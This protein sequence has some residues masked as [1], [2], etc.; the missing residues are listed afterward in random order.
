MNQ[1][2][3]TLVPKPMNFNFK[4]GIAGTLVA[5]SFLPVFAFAEGTTSST[6]SAN[7]FCA[8]ISTVSTKVADQI[9]EA[10]AK[11][12]KKQEDRST[13]IAKK[14]GDAD[15]RRA[16][17]RTT[18]DGKRASNW[19]K[20]AT[21]AKTDAQKAAVATYK[22]TIQDAVTARRTSV[23]TA[24]KAYRDGLTSAMTGH[25]TAVDAAM[26]AFKT[27]VNTALTKA[28]ADCTAGIASKTVSAS[29]N[30]SVSDARKVLRDAKKAAEMSSG[31]TALKQTR[32]TAIK[33]AEATFKAATEKARADLMLALKK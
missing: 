22:Q 1:I 25:S 33:A 26:S 18:A 12:S 7:G 8:R 16:V 4:K 3:A 2:S 10:E 5:F 23:D 15:A 19:D 9:T 17:G 14:E 21:K 13:N 29:F 11:Q 6:K 27:A 31:L 24:V 32:D 20:M 30:T 28:Q